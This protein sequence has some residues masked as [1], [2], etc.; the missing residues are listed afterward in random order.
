MFDIKG[1]K[2]LVAG[3][4]ASG[5]AAAQLAARKGALVKL[6]ENDDS[7][8]VR[9]RLKN[10][11][12]SGL[13]YE[14]GG[15]T[16]PFCADAELLV[17][18]PGMGLD[19][20]PAAVAREKGIPVVGEME[21]AFWFCPAPVI[22][23]TGTNGKSTTTE[24]VGRILSSSGFHAPVCGNIGTPLSS[25]VEALTEKS[26][27]VLEVSSFQLETIKEFKPLVAALLNISDD[28]YQRHVDYAGYKREKFK[29]F[30][31]QTANDWAVVHSDFQHDAMLESVESRIIYFG[32]KEER[33]GGVIRREEV[34]LEGGHN[35]EN[36]AC[37]IAI[38]KIMECSDEDIRGAVMTFKGLPHRF[39]KV[40]TC[41]EVEFLDDS[42]ATNV[43]A[44]KRALESLDRKAVL[45]AGGRDKGGDYASVLP[46]V[47]EKIKA[48]VLIG[49]ARE[50]MTRTFSGTVDV[51]E[52]ETMKEAVERAR[53]LAE[54]GDAVLLS[55]M[56]SSFDMFSSYAERGEVF[57]K[58][59]R[60]LRT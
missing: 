11:K 46:I 6:T 57:Q 8:E 26:V 52:A 39:E 36:V 23:I 55:P 9:N 50:K 37:A 41:D 3:L 58:E 1:K 44:A 22:A 30:S 29:I 32:G 49:E 15:H 51:F 34:P 59:V 28:H 35:I 4:G 5:F 56:C 54:K 27:A 19:S 12:V 43:D 20:F 40:C 24:L 48:M 53:R 10:L 45:I 42:K 38:A 47:K 13:E 25:V 17:V 31:N 60:K 33:V 16:A 7:G 18:S 21:F 2:V 14:A